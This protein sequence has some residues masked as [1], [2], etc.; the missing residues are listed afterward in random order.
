MEKVFFTT[1]ILVVICIQ[2]YGVQYNISKQENSNY[3]NRIK[4]MS[5]SNLV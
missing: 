1:W 2:Q 3:Q 4:T 5:K